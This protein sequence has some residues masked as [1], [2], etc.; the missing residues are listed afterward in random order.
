MFIHF[1]YHGTHIGTCNRHNEL[2]LSVD[3]DEVIGA[4]LCRARS[5]FKTVPTSS[6]VPMAMVFELV[7]CSYT[8]VTSDKEPEQHS[9]Q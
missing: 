3:L 7:H 9:Y 1:F 5:I 4:F 6:K 8:P 2:V